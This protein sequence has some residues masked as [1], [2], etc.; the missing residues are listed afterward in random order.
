MC[1]CLYKNIDRKCVCIYIHK[2]DVCFHI[3][4]TYSVC[5]GE[6]MVRTCC[7]G[8]SKGVCTC[9]YRYICVYTHTQS[10]LA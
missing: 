3:C 8:G 9:V 5:A 2:I 10:C 7:V 6:E 1:V 4:S